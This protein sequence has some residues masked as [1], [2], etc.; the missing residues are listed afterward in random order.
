MFFIL[1]LPHLNQTLI[2]MKKIYVLFGLIVVYSLL[3]VAMNKK[4]S[5]EKL[6][7]IWHV[8]VV[9]APLGYKDYEIE[10][11][12]D[13][14][15]YRAHVLFVE[16][17]YKILD[18]EFTLKDGKLTG[19]VVINEEIIDFTIWEKKGVVQGNAKNNSIG[20]MPMTFVRAKE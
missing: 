8:K 5:K 16:S 9:D 1:L 4:I 15:E 6:E 14:G 12:E 17:K 19:N 11:I 10:I 13:K 2:D 7:G 20:D 3:A 18:R